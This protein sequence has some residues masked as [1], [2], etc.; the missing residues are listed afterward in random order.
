MKY[1]RGPWKVERRSVKGVFGHTV[2]IISM[3]GGH[4]AEVSPNDIEAC[5][6]LIA[7]A[8]E[9]LLN[10]KYLLNILKKHGLT[11]EDEAVIETRKLIK[12]ATY[13]KH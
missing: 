9:L 1:T 3:D 4:I 6:A 13:E 11:E 7:M 8:P 2:H 12:E 5:A 10:A